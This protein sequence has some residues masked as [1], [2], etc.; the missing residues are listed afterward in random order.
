[1]KFKNYFLFALASLV[2]TPATFAATPGYT[3]Y[4][5]PTLNA[6][7]PPRP[8]P[9]PD[10]PA[11]VPAPAPPQDGNGQIHQETKTI[12]VR[13]RLINVAANLRMLAGLD[14]S[15]RGYTVES[16]EVDVRGGVYGTYMDLVINNRV[17]QTFLNPYGRVVMYPRPNMQIGR[18][19]DSLLVGVRGQADVDAIYVTLSTTG[20]VRPPRPPSNITI[21]V[22]INRRMIGGDAVY[23]HQYMDANRYR[24]YKIASMEVN[25]QASFQTALLDL[26]VNG[27]NEGPTMQLGPYPRSYMIYPINTEIGRDNIML[28]NR[29]DLMLRSITL[30]LS[31][32]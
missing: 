18:D 1:M 19:I 9:L 7:N 24:G 23:L 31:A 21:Q 22:P 3:P 2:L 12:I 4:S 14:E 16:V 30:R 20:P 32:Y 13:Q 17:E 15:Y 6:A 11:P 5:L 28:L 27:R 26:N 8:N 25:A 10:E 29:G